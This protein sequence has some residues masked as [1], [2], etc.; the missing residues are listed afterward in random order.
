MTPS[1]R[2]KPASIQIHRDRPRPRTDSPTAE[3]SGDGP[4]GSRLLRRFRVFRYELRCWRNGYIPNAAEAV[5]SPICL[6]SDPLL[7]ER[8]LALTP[9]LPCPVWGRDELHAGEMWNSNSIVAWLLSRS[10]IT[11]APSTLLAV[12]APPAGTPASSSPSGNSPPPRA[13]DSE[14]EGAPIR[15]EAVFEAGRPAGLTPGTPLDGAMA[16]TVGPLPLE[17]G[18]RYAWRLS[19]DGETDEDWQVGFSVRPSAQSGSQHV[20]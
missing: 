6:T 2:P 5:D 16:I 13:T 3:S 17:P 12:A 14:G 18:R 19:V 8:L 9:R 7:A 1:E 15:I 4:V 20:A 11:P 10:G